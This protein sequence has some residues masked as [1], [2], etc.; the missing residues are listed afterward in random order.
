A[1]QLLGL[2]DVVSVL[3]FKIDDIYR[4]AEAG[5]E[6]ERESGAG[7]A[8][9]NWM[10]QNRALFSALKMEKTVTVITIG[11]IVFVAALNILISLVM[12]VM[13]KVR[14]IAILVSLG[15]ERQHIRNIF[16]LQ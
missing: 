3:E 13:E 5:T 12:M 16:L 14:D 8:S 1:Q 7:F 2:S 6:L 4:A 11:L 9:T 15:A 10:E